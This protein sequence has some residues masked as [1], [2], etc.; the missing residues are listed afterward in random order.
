MHQWELRKAAEE[1]NNLKTIKGQ[2]VSQ[3]EGGMCVC[4]GG[5]VPDL[6]KLAWI[7]LRSFRKAYKHLLEAFQT[8]MLRGP[9]QVSDHSA[10]PALPLQEGWRNTSTTDGDSGSFFSGSFFV[11]SLIIKRFVLES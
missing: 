10:K 5:G 6:H 11:I 7:T 1:K 4:V 3:E 2:E 8:L 9:L